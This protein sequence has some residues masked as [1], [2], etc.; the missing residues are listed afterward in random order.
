MKDCLFC[1]IINGD[2][3]SHKVYEDDDYLAILD[4]FPNTKGLT[5]VIPKKHLPGDVFEIND[6]EYSK[7]MLAAK[8][9]AKL[10]EKKL[11]NLRVALVIE[12]LEIDHVHIKLYPLHGTKKGKFIQITDKEKPV[13]FEKYSGYVTTLHGPRADDKELKELAEKLRN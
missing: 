13:S 4:I 3:P 10:L 9:V 7:L 2:I 5:L 1:K 8:K 6:E 12:G 11:G